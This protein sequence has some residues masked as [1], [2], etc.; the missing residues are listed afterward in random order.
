MMIVDDVELNRV[1]LSQIFG[2]I[3]T[4]AEAGSGET[5][6]RF[7]KENHGHID[8]IL[9]DLI[10][11]VMDGFQLLQKLKEDSDLRDILVII[12]SQTGEDGEA[13]ALSMGAA[14]FIAK[15]Y[16]ADAAL[17]RVS[18]VMAQSKLCLM[19]R[20]K[21]LSREV[22]VMRFRVEHDSM[23]GLYNP[24]ALET[25]V[26]LA[27]SEDKTLKS[28]FY[29]IDLDNFKMINDAF[30]HDKGDEVLIAVAGILTRNFRKTDIVT[31]LGGNKF[32]VFSPRFDSMEELKKKAGQLCQ[33]LQMKYGG[34]ELA[35][36]VGISVAPVQ[37]TDYQTIYK[38]ADRVLLAAKRLGKRQYKI[39]DDHME[40]P[41]PV[42]SRNLDWLLD[43]TSDA[44]MVC[45][46][47]SYDVLYLNQVACE[48]AGRE[49]RNCIGKKCYEILWSKSGPCS[50]CIPLC[51]M[52][53]EYSEQE[54]SDAE[55]GK[56]YI[57]KGELTEWGGRAARIQF[58]QDNT[59][60][61]ATA[62]ELEA[63]S[64]D[65][66]RLLDLMPGEIFRYSAGADDRFDFVSENM[67]RMLSY[68]QETF[69][70]KL[71]GSFSCMVWHEDRAR[72]LKEVEKQ[73]AVG[74]VDECEYRIEKADGTLCWVHDIGHL[75]HDEAGR[76]WF[77]VTVIDITKEHSA[78]R[79]LEEERK[80]LQ[81]ALL[82][83]GLQYWEHDLRTDICCNGIKGAFMG[84]ADITPHYS[85]FLENS[86]IIPP[87]YV[88][89][90]KEKHQE[91]YDGAP[92][93]EY[94]IPLLA[95]S[96]QAL[97]RHIRCTNLFNE[98]G[99]PVKTIGTAENIEKLKQYEALVQD[100]CHVAEGGTDE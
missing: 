9:L 49:K 69:H 2:G 83:S 84:F 53:Q 18:N 11:P 54:V 91:L 46:L 52:S 7:A 60:R 27:F 80:K 70:K 89:L 59:E 40:M 93:V 61:A 4:I 87:A 99:K 25:A 19:D 1:V 75:V 34:V 35:A 31:R 98:A 58:M 5:T 38:N 21:A 42:L 95:S 68:T 12:T 47:E 78:T 48:I 96:G 56:Q 33:K 20:E 66:K 82:H 44:V 22:E 55:T 85:R 79:N 71:G 45:D 32:A 17:H 64:V 50:H 90:Y 23:T 28:C 63:L 8:I 88:P 86:G 10:M 29:M 73:T 24:T 26:N 51:E 6:Y 43:E 65:R 39:Y 74:T 81:I 13:R 76:P 37:G 92:F 14:D 30:G 97:W 15:P 94:E 67:L 57:L 62:R 100:A 16:N 36:T 41:S 3:Y 77:Y 72:V